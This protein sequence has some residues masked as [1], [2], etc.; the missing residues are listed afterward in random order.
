MPATLVAEHVP[1]VALSVPSV[2]VEELSNGE[3]TVALYA[4]DLPDGYRYKRGDEAQLVA[5]IIQG[6]NRV[7]LDR[8]RHVAA[9]EAGYRR[10]EARKRVTAEQKR[11]HAERFPNR[12]RDRRAG[13]LAALVTHFSSMSDEAR[14]RGGRFLL[15]GPC[16]EC[17][18]TRQVWACWAVDVDADWYEEGYGPC[19]LCGGAA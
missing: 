17:G 14:E 5:W 6:A 10:L 18:D 16:P 3:R 13:E 2:S 7:G 1:S 9:L 11:T 15:D 4:S 19:S 8:L 12:K